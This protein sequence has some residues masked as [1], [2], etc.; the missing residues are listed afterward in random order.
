[1]NNKKLKKMLLT[2]SVMSAPAIVAEVL[3]GNVAE[4][5]YK[6][7]L[8]QENGKTYF[9]K[10]GTKQTDV[11]ETING[12]KYYFE[13]RDWGSNMAVSKW[14]YSGRNK[15]WYYSDANGVVT[16]SNT[17]SPYAKN[18]K[19]EENG[20]TYFYKNGTKQTDVLETINGKK[21]YFEHRDWGSNMAVS[22]WSY[23]GRNKMWYYSDANGVVIK[24]STISPYVKNGKIEENGK[25]Y[26]YKNG[27]KQTDVLETINGKKYYFE[28][29]DWGSNMAVSKWSYSGRNKMWYYSDANGVVTKSSTISPYAKNGKIEE[30]GKTYFYKNGTK[31]S[32][33]LETINGKQYYFEPVG[34]GSNMAIS[35]WSRS[36][37]TNTWYYSDA[38]GVV[39]ITSKTSPYTQQKNG[40][41]QENGKKYFY[42]NGLKQSDVLETINGKQYYFEPVG[43]GSNMAISKWSRS[44]KT[45]TWYYSDANGVVTRTSKISPYANNSSTEQKTNQNNSSNVTIKTF[46][47]KNLKT[48]TNYTAEDLNN[49]IRQ[50]GGVTSKL[51][52]KGATFKEAERRYG[53]N[54][55]YLLS[56]AALESNWGRSRI[57]IDK[58]NFFGIAAY[59]NSPYE[60]ATKF[61]N[62]DAGI[63][64]A[65]RWINSRYLV[66]NAFPARGAY[67]GNKSGGMNVYYAT[68]PEWGY[69]IA[70]IMYSINEKSGRKDR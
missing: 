52:N 60:S 68:D 62:V 9:Y 6:N 46:Q 40:L 12:K 33:V 59:D 54:A 53:V 35:K 42:K 31:Q 43:W 58:N 32:D 64:G 3:D 39:T 36:E 1:M 8:V 24:T 56:H 4:A 55:L 11:L 34:W 17:I 63:L 49:I 66:G 37:K 22:K 19:I 10:N 25:T 67:L 69:K 23:S 21:Y 27:T 29:R 15:M 44:E 7:G 20:K 51:L 14:S 61:D 18:G 5:N 16:K 48:T 57:A 38:N 70:R 41:V 65:A 28:H 45:N 47:Y 50:T 30:N 2:L 13:H 26:F